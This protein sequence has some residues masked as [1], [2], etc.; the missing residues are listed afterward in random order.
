MYTDFQDQLRSRLA[1]INDA[2][3]FNERGTL[4]SG[5][6]VID[7]PQGQ[8]LNFKSPNCLD[9]QPD[10]AKTEAVVAEFGDNLASALETKLAHL[11]G[12]EACLLFNSLTDAYVAIS[13]Q[14]LNRS[15]A[16]IYDTPSLYSFTTAVSRASKYKFHGTDLADLEKQLKLSQ[17]QQNRLIVVDAVNIASGNIAPLNQIFALADRYRAMVAVDET[18][19]TGIFMNGGGASELLDV[20]GQAE[21]TVGSLTKAFGCQSGAYIAGRREIIDYLRQPTGLPEFASPMTKTD[22]AA[23]ISAIDSLPQNAVKRQ[24]L[25]QITNY[26]IRKLYGEGFE[27]PPTQ[28][29][30]LAVMVGDNQK[31]ELFARHLHRNNVL[32]T[33]LAS[34]LIDSQNARIVVQLSASHTQE[35][36]EQ[37]AKIF[38][39]VARE[40]GILQ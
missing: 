2:G 20:K 19:A 8:V 33:C 11:L 23:A 13:A 30:I 17:A 14:L 9:N 39:K 34:P 3:L 18:N 31:A 37:T 7:T 4:M 29:A 26:L 12:A 27:I 10:T 1:A 24:Y 21:L 38:G 5:A 15:D 28:S 6:A 25:L 35:Q 32:V 36:I 22:M 40:I 16:I